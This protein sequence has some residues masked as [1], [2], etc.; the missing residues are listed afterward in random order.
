VRVTEVGREPNLVF[1]LAVNTYSSS[2]FPKRLVDKQRRVLASAVSLTLNLG[3]RMRNLSKIQTYN[4]ASQ[5]ILL[6]RGMED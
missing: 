6:T 5:I 2:Y 1:L 4:T 3:S